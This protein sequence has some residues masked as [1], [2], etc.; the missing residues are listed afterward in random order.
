MPFIES[1]VSIPVT[2]Q[3]EEELK[4]RLG[5]AVTILGKSETWLMVEIEDNKRLYFQGEKPERVGFVEVK[6]YGRA[7]QRSYERMTEEVSNIFESVLQIPKDKLYV[8]Y[9]E[10][11]HWGFNGSNF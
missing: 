1:K 8:A 9:Q 3:Q 7:D 4:T 11:S 6:L 5:K 10:Y 2:R